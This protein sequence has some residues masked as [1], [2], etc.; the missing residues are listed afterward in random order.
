M[1]VGR[2][3]VF[4]TG[5]DAEFAFD[6]Y[7]ELVG[8]VNNLLGEGNVFFVGE[9]RT[10][11][12]NR[13]EAAVDAAL[14]EL[15]AIAVVEVK[16]DFGIFPAEFLGVCYGTLGHVAQEGGVCIVA[17]ALG[18]LENYGRFFFSSCLDD[19]LELLHVVEVE[20]GDCITALDGFLK[21][22]A[23]VDKA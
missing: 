23:S 19:G 21:H 17:G 7:I 15:E 4:N 6:S 9:V 16:N 1:V 5:E 14:A 12:H 13:R 11:D 3:F 2:N 22:L 18:N 20:S 10:V 8:V